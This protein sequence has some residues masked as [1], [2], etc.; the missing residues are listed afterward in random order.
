M[1]KFLII[2]AVSVTFMSSCA[3]KHKCGCPDGK[4][5]CG[6]SHADKKDGECKDCKK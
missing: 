1:S 6:H 3:H 2:L 5:Q 4:C